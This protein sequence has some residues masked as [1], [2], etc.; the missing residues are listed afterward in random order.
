MM[1]ILMGLIRDDV[2]MQRVPPIAPA[3]CRSRRSERPFGQFLQP[4]ELRAVTVYRRQ[5]PQGPTGKV[6]HWE[7]IKTTIRIRV[8]QDG[9]RSESLSPRCHFLVSLVSPDVGAQTEYVCL[10][11]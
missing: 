4:S 5:P 11:N 7:I 10:I 2:R 3:P 1:M 8:A 6:R 9:T